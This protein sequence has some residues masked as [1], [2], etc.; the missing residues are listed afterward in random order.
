MDL[1][2]EVR[3][4]IYTLA[5][6][7]AELLAPQPRNKA[8][9]DARVQPSLT[10]TSRQIRY[11]SL[12]IFYSE[13]TFPF[14]FEWQ[15]FEDPEILRNWAAAI[16]SENA[17]RI[18]R[19]N[20]VHPIACGQGNSF[21]WA[22]QTVLTSFTFHDGIAKL[23]GSTFQPPDTCCSCMVIEQIGAVLH[24]VS[25]SRAKNRL[26]T[27]AQSVEIAFR[28]VSWDRVKMRFERLGARCDTCAKS[29]LYCLTDG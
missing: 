28:P 1:P 13:N 19:V 18:A 14:S 29:R 5:L 24:S 8:N 6:V 3:N 20:I 12:L 21:D 23:T 15:D 17:D 26:Q 9:T 10:R 22:R 7:H 2:G 11:E 4:R 25:H 16:G 27:F